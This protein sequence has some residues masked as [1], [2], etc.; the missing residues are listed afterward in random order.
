MK[1]VIPKNNLRAKFYTKFLTLLKKRRLSKNFC[2]RYLKQC[3]ESKNKIEIGGLGWAEHHRH[4]C[5]DSTTGLTGSTG[6]PAKQNSQH[7]KISDLPASTKNNF[8]EW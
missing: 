5:A 4:T 8:I 2:F 7:L 1:L 3:H 6:Q